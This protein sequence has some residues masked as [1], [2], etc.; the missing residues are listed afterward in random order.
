[1]DKESKANLKQISSKWGRTVHRLK[2]HRNKPETNKKKMLSLFD[3]NSDD[4]SLG[5]N[6][7]PWNLLNSQL[8]NIHKCKSTD[9]NINTIHKKR[10]SSENAKLVENQ[11]KTKNCLNV[12]KKVEIKDKIKTK[13]QSKPLVSRNFTINDNQRKIKPIS[14]SKNMGNYKTNVE[15]GIKNGFKSNEKNEKKLFINKPYIKATNADDKYIVKH[16]RI[17]RSV[18][19]NVKLE[20][21]KLQE[22]NNLEPVL[23][24]KETEMNDSS[25]LYDDSKKI[26]SNEMGS[27]CQSKDPHPNNLFTKLSPLKPSMPESNIDTCNNFLS[28]VDDVLLNDFES[29]L[30]QKMKKSFQSPSKNCSFNL[31]P[32]DAGFNSKKWIKSSLLSYTLSPTKK[33]SCSFFPM[34]NKSIIEKNKL[35][36]PIS[37]SNSMYTYIKH[38]RDAEESAKLGERQDYKDEFE[39]V[40]SCLN[41]EYDVNVRILGCYRLINQIISKKAFS[42]F[43]S[44][45]RQFT[46]LFYTLSDTLISQ[47]DN[48]NPKFNALF[49]FIVLLIT[50]PSN[51]HKSMLN[52]SIIQYIVEN[53]DNFSN[54]LLWSDEEFLKLKNTL[55]A[56]WYTND[57]Y[58]LNINQI[59]Y[60]DVIIEILINILPSSCT[61]SQQ[62]I[63]SPLFKKSCTMDNVYENLS[64]NIQRVIND[65]DIS[66]V[67]TRFFIIAVARR[68]KILEYA[69]VWDNLINNNYCYVENQIVNDLVFIFAYFHKILKN[70]EAD[71]DKYIHVD[72]LLLDVEKSPKLSICK[73]V[74]TFVMSFL[75]FILNKAHFSESFG[76]YLINQSELMDI[77]LTIL[78]KESSQYDKNTDVQSLILSIFINIS[79]VSKSNCLMLFDM[80]N[81]LKLNKEPIENMFLFYLLKLLYE[82]LKKAESLENTI[83]DIDWDEIKKKAKYMSQ[84]K[85]YGIYEEH[86][87]YCALS[88][89]CSLLIGFF[90]ENETA[91]L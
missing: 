22:L 89:Y 35:E 53:I 47:T 50:C 73:L 7:E 54:D 74:N 59:T 23:D 43:I 38:V 52:K 37:P 82:S 15:I 44:Q 32:N 67:T 3:F 46:V 33:F 31:E 87:Q 75:K 51:R 13:I 81:N 2:I 71:N 40:I 57:L 24:V 70:N 62:E 45:K 14:K 34:P 91:S 79:E 48:Y 27:N 19:R 20:H 30:S 84:S 49:S 63:Y 12:S 85:E 5:S 9:S 28:I 42:F 56:N 21:V 18:S 58:F 39:D 65:K 4:E 90:M 25:C 77:L 78:Q 69:N 80:Y 36:K 83:K 64:Q 72:K 61:A 16:S 11:K 29:K 88:T 68:L 41:K 6:I 1:M 86:V 26:F 8:S 17:T 60:Q 76:K 66:N 10:K 55:E